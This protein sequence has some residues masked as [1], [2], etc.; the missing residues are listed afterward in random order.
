MYSSYIDKVARVYFLES[1][2]TWEYIENA[3]KKYV[4]KTIRRLVIFD[5][6]GKKLSDLEVER[7]FDERGNVLEEKTK[8]SGKEVASFKRK[9]DE[10]NRVIEEEVKNTLE[11]YKRQLSFH[12][13]GQPKE[14]I[15]LEGTKKSKVFVYDEGNNLITEERYDANGSLIYKVEYER[16]FDAWGNWIK[17]IRYDWEKEPWEDS[18]KKTPKFVVYRNFEYYE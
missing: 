16:F 1:E 18:L 11:S 17:V 10:Q 7:Q 4:E 8:L 14:I 13:S 12:A 9:F 3:T 6:S 5:R 15:Y 2:E